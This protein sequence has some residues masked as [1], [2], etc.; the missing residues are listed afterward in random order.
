LD[1]ENKVAVSKMC[2][3]A[4]RST[5]EVFTLDNHSNKILNFFEQA[6]KQR[7]SSSL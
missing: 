2:K 3:E 6:L 4:R 1:P 7:K 5:L